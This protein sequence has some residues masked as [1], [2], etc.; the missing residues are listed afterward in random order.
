MCISVEFGRNWARG[1]RITLIRLLV[2]AIG[3]NRRIPNRKLLFCIQTQNVKR[4]ATFDPV[5]QTGHYKVAVAFGPL[6]GSKRE[7]CSRLW[8][9]RRFLSSI[10]RGLSGTN[11][12]QYSD[13]DCLHPCSWITCV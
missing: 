13:E 6:G 4:P 2:S 12:S 9:R 1:P 7:F 8:N 5:C 3:L 10:E 11:A